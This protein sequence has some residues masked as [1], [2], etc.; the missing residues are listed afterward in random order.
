MFGWRVASP[1]IGC[2]AL[3]RS[4]RIKVPGDMGKCHDTGEQSLTFEGMWGGRERDGC[5]AGGSPLGCSVGA[6]HILP[7]EMTPVSLKWHH[8]GGEGGKK[9]PKTALTRLCEG[10]Y[11]CESS[12]CQATEEAAGDNR[13][14]ND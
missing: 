6:T 10:D 3:C 2:S 5:L 14:S 11:V 1:G 8:R 7:W 12:A 13:V 9:H 4:A